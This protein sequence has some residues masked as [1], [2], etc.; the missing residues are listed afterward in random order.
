MHYDINDC[1]NKG[2]LFITEDSPLN[3]VIEKLQDEEFNE[4]DILRNIND[5]ILQL[6]DNQL[7]LT[8]VRLIDV[9]DDNDLIATTAVFST[10]EL[11]SLELSYWEEEVQDCIDILN[12]L[13][14]SHVDNVYYKYFPV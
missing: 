8:S 7:E 1:I 9:I 12:E 6:T 10:A 4:D 11:S 2:E 5:I 3:Q 13:P 14:R